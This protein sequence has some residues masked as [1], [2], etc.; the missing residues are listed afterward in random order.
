[1]DTTANTLICD[2]CDK[3]PSVGVAAISFIP[4]SI[5]WCRTC[6]D[7]DVIPYW[8]AIYNTAE[9]GGLDQTTLEWQELVARTL[10]YF[11][12]SLEQFNVDVIKEKKLFDDSIAQYM[13][14]HHDNQ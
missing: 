3:N 7:A 9:C 11:G 4:M 13:K 1:M 12:K 5:A 10:K 6:L 8:A 2:C 14:E